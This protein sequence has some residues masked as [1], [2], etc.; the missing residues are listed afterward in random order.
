MPCDTRTLPGQSLTDRKT[1]V[2]EAIKALSAGL[3][4]GKIKTVVSKEGALAFAGWDD[5]ARN[6]V[7]DACAYRLLMVK[8]SSL[9]KAKVAQA[10][11]ISGFSVNR[12]VIGAGV[13][14]HDGGKTWHNGH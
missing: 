1:E 9:A 8:G 3:V 13:H 14:S 5:K 7:T 6:R 2:L 10:Q 11:Q 12:Q 4:S